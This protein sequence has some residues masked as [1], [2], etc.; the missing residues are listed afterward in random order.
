MRSFASIFGKQNSADTSFDSQQENDIME[1][2]D[3]TNI[4]MASGNIASGD[5]GKQNRI[6]NLEINGEQ[7]GKHLG[8]ALEQL[9]WGNVPKCAEQYREFSNQLVHDEIVEPHKT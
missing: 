7:V 2:L 9:Q 3:T 8:R 1:H 5:E 6:M 4:N